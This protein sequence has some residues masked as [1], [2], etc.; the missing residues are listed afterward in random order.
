MHLSRLS[1]VQ[2]LSALVVLVAYTI[3][4][5][6]AHAQALTLVQSGTRY[7]GTIT[8]GFN[9]DFGPAT[10]VSLNTPS[11]IV[12]DSNGN[13]YISDTLNNCVRKI[14]TSGSMSTLVGL[15]VSGKGDTCSTASNSTPTPAQGLY[16]PTGLAVDS[17]NNLYIADSSHN[18]VRRLA[19]GA[20]GVASLTTVSGTCGSAV[21][22]T[23]NP[24]GLVLDTSN[25]LYI[26]IQD[27]EVPATLSNYQVLLQAPA[28]SL[29]VVAGAPSALV[30]TTCVGITGSVALNGP[31]GLAISG[32]GDL[33]IADTGNNCVRQ[34]VGL[35]TFQTAVGQCS[36]DNSGTIATGLDRPYG[37]AF[38]PTQ[39]LYITETSPDVVVSY[40]LGSGST[41]I[42]AGLPNGAS[43]SYSPVQDGTSALNFPLNGPRGMAV[44]SL[45]N[46]SLA[47]SANSILRKLSSNII[48]PATPVGSLS[49]GLPVTF[50][51]N[52]KV[53]LTV[54]SG[55]DFNITTNTCT[56]VLTPAAPGAPP[57]T[58]QVFVR[59]TP[60][61][62]GLRSA[63]I[64]LVDSISGNSI[65]QGLEGTATGS[66][67]VFTPGIVKTVVS[68]LTAPS[69]V[70]VDPAGNAYILETGAT[71]G[72]GN[73]LFLPVSGGIPFPII[74]G[75]SGLLTSSAIAIDSTGNYFITD[76]VHG[77][78][79]RFGV[80]GSLNTSYVTGLNTP[81]S[82]YVD[83]FD[84]LF[85]AQ[86]GSAHNVI[87]VFAGGGS[88]TIA[89]S[90][91][92]TSADGVLA[93]TASFVSPGGLILDTTGIL[94]IADTGG[95]LVYA[96][97]KFGIIHQVAGNGA[98]TTTVPGQATGT[99]ILAPSSLAFDAAGDL[100]IADATAN[101]VYTVFVSTTSNG[102]NISTTLGTGI[103]GNTGDGGFAN[104]AQISNPVSIAVEG[105]SYLFEVDNG[106]SA[107]REITYPNPTL[108]FGSVV[109]GQSSF[110][111]Q[112]TLSNFGSAPFTL[113][114]AITSSD[115]HFTIDPGTTTCG[116]TIIA[117]STCNLGFVFTPTAMGSLTASVSI[118]S[119]AY[120]SPLTLTLTGTGRVIAPLQFTLPAETE[121]YGQPF[122]QA[123]N[124]TN[125]SPSPTG[126]I[127]FSLG[128]RVLCTV[129]ATLG[130][131]STCNALNT[132]LAVG[133]YGITFTYSGDTNYLP[134]TGNTTLTVTPAPLTVTVNSIS[135]LYG[136]SNPA[137]TGSLT[138]VAS[139]D[140][141]L[142]AYSSVATATS[143]VGT[144]PIIAT[145]TTAGT[146]S[147]S[148]YAVTNTPG[149]LTVTP[150]P[151][152]VTVI[153]VSRQY[154]QSNPP[155]N[156]TT[157]GVLNGNTVSGGTI[158]GDI[159]TI[160]YSSPATVTSPAGTYPI[161]ATITGANAGNYAVIVTP[162]TL[163]VTQAILTITV[164]NATRIY[165]AANPVFT[166][167]V[168]GAL[169]GDTFTNSYSTT[170]TVA[171]PVGSYPI[172]DTV[173]GPASSNYT[174]QVTPGT[175]AITQA[176]VTVNVAAN[177][178]TRSYGAADP[179]FTSTVTGALNGD[180]FIITYATTDTPT[181]AV[182]T[183]IVVP[184]VSGPA[185]SNYSTVTTTNGTLTISPATLTVTANNATR[186]Y[187]T[188][189]PAFT[190]T[191]SGLLK[192][193][194]VATTYSSP[195]V[196]NSPVGAY[197]IIP[198]VSGAAL[199][200][201]SVN[202]VNGSLS[203]TQN[204][205][206]LVINVNSAS[207]LYGAPNPAFS[208]TVTGVVPGDDVVVS[209]TT[210][211]TPASPAGQYSIGASVSGTSAG[212]YIATIHPGTLDV[213]PIN[214]VT[215]V[216]SSGSPAAAGAN[217][218]FTGT[219]TSTTGVPTGTVNFSDG[220][221]LLGTGTINSSGVATFST[222]ALTSGSHTITASFQANTNFSTSSATLTQIINA[223]VGSFTI[224]ATPPTQL[225]RGPGTTTYQVT[226]TS[227]GGFAGQINLSCSGLPAD[228][229]CTFASNPTLT[230]GGTAT[231]ALTINTTAADAKL[232]DPSIPS[233]SPG[234]LAPI[235]AAAVFPVE[236]TGL[237]I[238]FAGLRRRRKPGTQ[239]IRLLAVILLSFGIL[240]L[241]GCCFNTTFQTYTVSVTGTSASLT[242]QAQ[243][244]S[245]FLSVG[246]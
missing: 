227:V 224:S 49:A 141:V 9:G 47:D 107:V 162:G 35:A 128:A 64:K 81:T 93:T 37:L 1:G 198:S 124:V 113:N 240:G 154:G 216:T 120:N 167:T 226:L 63:P 196:I 187:D 213:S 69:A 168:S 42:V 23:P 218:T 17:T 217:V 66:L 77:T 46:F 61:L 160:A 223:P 3:T 177:N 5:S 88:R 144:Y 22:A 209:Y 53:N 40:V 34:V 142:V 239:K 126:T 145:L 133:T 36:N 56:G 94:Y 180:T 208:G 48:F 129:S 115:P 116:T 199:S 100:Y 82:I 171:S 73:L 114:G 149:I 156:S 91:N 31:S 78:V 70:T 72:T 148:N 102:S 99:A 130:V 50:A 4:P 111:V 24:N 103:A 176:S 119:N 54:T 62:L 127:T 32:A 26:A 182:G 21:S 123:V 2:T 203:I 232:R 221:N 165:G 207:R 236:L 184:T 146:T 237:G 192:G 15:A 169:N 229:T 30:P 6:L 44:D 215:T 8:P 140:T 201:Y 59:F 33:F 214:T 101:L 38:S 143:P 157:L 28:A 183:Y 155:F 164:A 45:G 76:A 121:V 233:L 60:T 228:A 195:A 173:G 112:Q 244:T 222:S 98:A 210:T 20:S 79:A 80:D 105:N 241:A 186:V 41:T 108:A 83:G 211:A 150:I 246:N 65:S 175:L 39:S 90:G 242:T 58:C 219:V 231:V 10:T 205:A 193:D 178:A 212:N 181:S 238:F 89:G 27:T 84:N 245:V 19:A 68:A 139:G 74:P 225:I 204:Q 92:N 29:C 85:I 110:V 135:R 174:I 158:N 194:A 16:Q 57:V 71:P 166:S 25:N 152:T 104:L 161:N 153:N 125:S 12:F 86:A 147:L 230:A 243:S 190:G 14:D 197:P 97:D 75:G 189:N 191:T 43:G 122:S 7:A 96:V 95:H 234:D 117:G 106:N 200:N 109:V 151:I 87:E 132:G 134:A 67:G 136:A 206:A 170:A 235:T 138:G 159:L 55:P 172:N 179:T 11:Y 51:V 118:I 52:Q 137:F 188:A 220:S 185:T 13:Q 163:T 202:L 18:C 131:G